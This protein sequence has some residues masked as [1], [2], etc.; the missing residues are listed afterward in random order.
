[1]RCKRW[2]YK[3]RGSSF[4]YDSSNT[5]T[6]NIP[7]R[8]LF[9]GVIKKS[10]ST[11]DLDSI[12]PGQHANRDLPQLHYGLQLVWDISLS[13]GSIYIVQYSTVSQSSV[14][15]A[16]LHFYS[17][18]WTI[19]NREPIVCGMGYLL[20]LVIE[21]SCQGWT[22]QLFAFQEHPL[23]TSQFDFESYCTRFIDFWVNLM[24]WKVGQW[25]RRVLLA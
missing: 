21:Q 16:Y 8:T 2:R 24:Q 12:S 17:P 10:V 4:Y 23:Y 15:E 20:L 6:L 11:L 3:V 19:E 9:D 13:T 25:G 22:T 18:H 14:Q 5:I 1:M 7:S